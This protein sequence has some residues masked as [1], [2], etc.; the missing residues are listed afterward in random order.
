[1]IQIRK[2]DNHI[3]KILLTF[4][5]LDNYSFISIF[6]L[7][8]LVFLRYSNNFDEYLFQLRFSEDQILKLF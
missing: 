4:Y 7:S 3:L 1:M 8:L 2:C 5:Q 6:S